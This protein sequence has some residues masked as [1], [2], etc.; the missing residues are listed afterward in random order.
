MNKPSHDISVIMPAYNEGKKIFDNLLETAT[1]LDELGLSYEIILVD[2]GSEDST[3]DFVKKAIEFHPQI[4]LVS[5]QQNGG[6]GKAIMAGYAKTSGKIV[7]FLDADL[8]LHPKQLPRLIH[9]MN[10]QN[11]DVVIGSKRHP[12]SKISY[13][14]KRKMLSKGYNLYIKTLFDINLTDTQ[15]GIKLF[16]THVLQK[17]FS[18]IIVKRYAFDLELLINAHADGFKIVEAPIELIFNRENGGRIDVRDVIHMFI[19]TM[20]IF[21]RL[22]ILNYY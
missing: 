3:A 8:E 12:E 19:D 14:V 9:E 18:K 5:Y 10:E 13:P 20:G 22:K 7:A 4:S 6:K 2:D 17:E 1:S 15:P 21:Y 16:K 11:A